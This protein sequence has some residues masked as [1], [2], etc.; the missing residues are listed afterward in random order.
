MQAFH[1]RSRR[2]LQHLRSLIF[3]SSGLARLQTMWH[4]SNGS[5]CNLVKMHQTFNP[6]QKHIHNFTFTNLCYTFHFKICVPLRSAGMLIYA[7]ACKYSRYI[8]FTRY[9][10]SNLTAR[11]RYLHI[12]SCQD[13]LKSCVIRTRWC[14]YIILQ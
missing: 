14:S 11:A 8:L 2:Y 3:L 7:T 5:F 1:C 12:V 9:F 4:Y 13:S 6:I 10:Y